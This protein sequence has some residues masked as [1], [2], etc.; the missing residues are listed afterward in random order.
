[1][2][3]HGVGAV[4]PLEVV[5]HVDPL[6]GVAVGVAPDLV[7]FGAAVDAVVADAT[8]ELVGARETEIT[9]VEIPQRHGAIG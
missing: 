3:E 1:M 7:G 6:A 9:A 4:V 2:T 8:A 5:V